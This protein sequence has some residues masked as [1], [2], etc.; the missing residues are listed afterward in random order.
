MDWDLNEFF[1]PVA[2]TREERDMV[3]EGEHD[4]WI[5]KVVEDAKRLRV[6]LAHDDRRYGLVFADFP[7]GVGWA[8]RIV[9]ELVTALGLT[10]AEWKAIRPDTLKDRLVR[11]RVYHKVGNSGRTF[12]NV[13]GF[14]AAEA[15]PPPAAKPAA[16]PVAKRTPT[17]KADA[18]SNVPDDDIPF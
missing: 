5:M 9:G 1:E 13:G 14:S 7:K 8:S 4:L 11:A 15:A 6:D 17:Q 3:P 10:P 16:K 2:A 18:A 12:V